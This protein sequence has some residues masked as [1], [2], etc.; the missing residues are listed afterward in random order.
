MTQISGAVTLDLDLARIGEAVALRV[1]A[2]L[3]PEQL[4]ER[5]AEL[6]AAR[7][8]AVPEQRG[9]HHYHREVPDPSAGELPR[10]VEGYPL[11]RWADPPERE[12]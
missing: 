5:V 12:Q 3:D 8:A 9:E 10:N 4:A 11:G 7:M 1:A 2:H 6:V